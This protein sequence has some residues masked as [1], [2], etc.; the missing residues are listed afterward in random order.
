MSTRADIKAARRWVVKV[1][2]ALLTDDGRGLDERVITD[3][4]AQLN[5]L[6]Q[7][8]AEVVL[9]SS[10]AVAAGIVRLGWAERPRA[11]HELQAAAAVGQS[12]LVQ[13]YEAA[14]RTHG[15]TTAQVLLGHDDVIARDRYL[16]ARGTLNTLLGMGVVPIVNEND[17]VVTEEIRFGDNDT[18]AALVANLIDADALVLLTDQLGLFR[19]DPRH[20]PDAELI[21][22]S[23]VNAPELDAM[24]GDGGA[25]G[26]GGM[27]TKLRA[28]RLAARSG[29][30]TVIAS[31]RVP[32]VLALIAA[33]EPEGSWLRTGKRPQNARKQWLASMVQIQGSVELDA[34][35]VKVLL[36]SGRSLLPVG[37]RAVSGTFARGDM[38]SCRDS[39]GREV[40]RGLVNYNADETRKIMGSASAEIETILG[41]GGDEELIHRDNLVLI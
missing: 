10:G 40:A 41:Y 32:E 31:G 23:D 15:I 8:G 22:E 19:E 37:V 11:L 28:A 36:D 30:E 12:A 2:S 33:G 16:N 14:F 3:L 9:V 24:A 6:R 4:V 5:T 35:A 21:S 38:V 20:N 17:T 1:G 13:S 29:T 25:L 26:R 27:V 39:Q 34:G 18:L 7:G